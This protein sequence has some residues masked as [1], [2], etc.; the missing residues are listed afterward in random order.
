MNLYFL[1]LTVILSCT[2]TPNTSIRDTSDSL[3]ILSITNNSFVPILNGIVDNEKQC[4]YY[5]KNLLFSIH[6]QTK[7]SETIIVIDSPGNRKIHIGDEL[8]CF[9]FRDHLFFVSGERID[10]TIFRK[11]NLRKKVNW[12]EPNEYNKKEGGKINL[13]MIEDDTFSL[14][15]FNYKDNKFKM[16]EERSNCK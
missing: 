10:N 9:V 12:Y 11:T 2:T 1:T 14:W 5:S 4:S 15:V 3:S 6:F 8:G 16:I 7:D 13:D